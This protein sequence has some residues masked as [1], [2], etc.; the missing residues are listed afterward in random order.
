MPMRIPP[1]VR[2]NA[3]I[4]HVDEDSQNVHDS[5]VNKALTNNFQAIKGDPQPIGD[6]INLFDG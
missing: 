3:V 1:L 5:A 2:Q 4:N 6:L